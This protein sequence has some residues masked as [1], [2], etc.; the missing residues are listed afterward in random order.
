MGSGAGGDPWGF[1]LGTAPGLGCLALGLAF[2]LAGLWWIETIARG[3][4][5]VA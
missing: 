4:E 3:A 1:L 2:G 5:E